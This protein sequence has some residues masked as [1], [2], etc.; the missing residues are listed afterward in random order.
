MTEISPVRL[1]ELMS[2]VGAAVSPGSAQ[3]IYQTL[4]N[5]LELAV[6]D[7]LI[8]RSPLKRQHKPVYKRTEKPAWTPQEVRNILEKANPH[9][10]A[11]LVTVAMVGARIGE[12]LA[13]QWRHV[14]FEKS[15]VLIEQTLWRGDIHDVKNEES[16]VIPMHDVLI[17][18]LLSHK[19]RSVFTEPDDF[20]F[21]REDGRWLD[22]GC[23]RKCVLN[24]AIK[25]AGI[26]QKPFVH[27]FHSFRHTAATLIYHHHKDVKASQTYLGHRTPRTTDIYLHDNKADPEAAAT[28]ERLVFGEL[29]QNVTRTL[30]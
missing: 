22:D 17:Q 15:R 29:L 3:K 12:V 27:S 21:C 30:Q 5:I 2:K 18:T 11:L 23:L 4:H 14:D 28:L 8:D 26:A 24:P 13:L 6:D 16:R 7:E 1:D 19:A 20:V 10:R 25:A 9:Y